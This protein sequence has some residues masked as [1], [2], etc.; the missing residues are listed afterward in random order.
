MTEDDSASVWCYLCFTLHVLLLLTFITCFPPPQLTKVPLKS[1]GKLKG[2]DVILKLS[3]SLF[4]VTRPQTHM[5][6]GD[7]S[8]CSAFELVLVLRLPPP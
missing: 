2:S 1:G 3:L 7:V 8:L 4:H 6:P 5:L